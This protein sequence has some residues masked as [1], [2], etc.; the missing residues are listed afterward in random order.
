MSYSVRAIAPDAMNPPRR[1]IATLSTVFDAFEVAARQYPGNECV[2]VPASPERNY[3]SD[4]LTW[5]YAEVARMVQD[6][7]ARY[8]DAGYG[9]GHRVATMLE[10]RPVFIVH[11]LALNSLGVS[12]V[13]INLESTSSEVATLLIRSRPVLVLCLPHLK[14]LID[15]AIGQVGAA[16][17]VVAEEWPA[18]LPP[19]RTQHLA[20]PPGPLTETG[21]LFT[22][23]TT[24]I[25]KGA[26][27]TNESMLFNGDRYTKAGGLMQLSQ[28]EERLYNPLPLSYANAFAH[29]NVAMILVA[30]CMIF[31]DRFHPSEWWREVVS[32][33]ATII[34]HLGIIVPV[35]LQLPP[36]EDESR[37]KVKFGAGGGVSVSQH[38]A[39][40]AR[41]GFPL[42]EMYGM[43]ELGI[44]SFASQIPRSDNRQQVGAPI[45]GVEFRIVDGEGNEVPV[46]EAGEVT[47]R[48]SGANPRQGFFAG[49]L[50][51]E[52]LTDHV[53]RNGWYHTGDLLRADEHGGYV[54]VDRLK[55]MIR[56]SGENISASQVENCLRDHPDVSQVACVPA[57][58]PLR[59][60]EVVACI[61]LKPHAMANRATAVSLV[62]W[63]LERIAYFKAPGGVIFVS[64]LPTTTSKKL[65]KFRIFAV[66]E[67]VFGRLDCFDLRSMKQRRKASTVSTGENT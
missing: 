46:G 2:C 23:G 18:A 27:L 1:D 9:H 30:G 17:N 7:R 12:L 6:A 21:L 16:I 22:S 59:Q 3:A 54:F 34:H 65:Q 63:S 11:W 39:W 44:C 35:L 36:T 53:W 26:I 61:V 52:A 62:A 4:G 28:G 40:E 49:Y 58:D 32:T 43:T 20:M 60:E 37:H 55:H 38:A 56:R 14:S 66:G 10:N 42:I 57:P 29:S 50:D 64:S 24:G 41:F 67:D 25:P 31:P 47:V 8:A 19:C 45:E 33:K 51:D 5:T 13:P 15:D 48:R